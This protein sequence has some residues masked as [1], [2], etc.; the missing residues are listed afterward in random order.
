[1]LLVPVLPAQ[2]ETQAEAEPEQQQDL[3]SLYDVHAY[4]MDLHVDP[5]RQ[6][7]LLKVIQGFSLREIARVTGLTPGNAAY[8]LNKALAGLAKQLKSSGVI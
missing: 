7:L 8:R 3:R 4:R 6:V 1:M 2:A 5:D